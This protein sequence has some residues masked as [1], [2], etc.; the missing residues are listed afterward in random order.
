MRHALPCWWDKAC[1][2]LLVGQR[3]QQH[4]KS[5]ISSVDFRCC[6]G[7][8]IPQHSRRISNCPLHSYS[9]KITFTMELF[10]GGTHFL[11]GGTRIPS[12]NR[13]I[14][15]KWNYLC[16]LPSFGWIRDYFYNMQSKFCHSFSTL[17]KVVHT[18]H[19]LQAGYNDNAFPE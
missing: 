18:Y 8:A 12:K 5:T 16:T 9:V 3:Y 4:L 19:F 2:S 7:G 10:V 11:V 6:C 1:T 15:T 13:I 17:Q 14:R